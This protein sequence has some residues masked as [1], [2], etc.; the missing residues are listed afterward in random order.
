[1]ERIERIPAAPAGRPMRRAPFSRRTQSSF[2]VVGRLEMAFRQVAVTHVLGLRPILPAQKPARDVADGRSRPDFWERPRG[3]AGSDAT[4]T[5]PTP[6][7][8]RIA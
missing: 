6:A 4:V 5:L 2:G 8:A 3:A 7:G 1:M